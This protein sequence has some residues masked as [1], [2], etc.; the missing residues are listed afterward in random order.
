MGSFFGAAAAGADGAAA[1]DVDCTGVAT[2]AAGVPAPALAL[3]S[4][5]C[6]SFSVTTRGGFVVMMVAVSQSLARKSVISAGFPP[7]MILT[8]R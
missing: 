7:R 8:P 1:A 6:T 2:V 5:A 3:A 4:V